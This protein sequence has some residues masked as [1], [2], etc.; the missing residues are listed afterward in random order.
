MIF[1]KSKI[2]NIIFFENA[3][4]AQSVEHSL[5]KAEV[6][7]SILLVGSNLYISKK[8]MNYKCKKKVREKLM[9]ICI[10]CGN[11]MENDVEVCEKCGTEIKVVKVEPKEEKSTEPKVKRVKTEKTAK[12]FTIITFLI[13][14]LQIAIV[15][16][17]FKVNMLFGI[18]LLFLTFAVSFVAT[19]ISLITSLCAESLMLIVVNFSFF[20]LE[21]IWGVLL[22]SHKI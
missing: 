16:P 1:T 21:M 9:K 4:I 22:I 2:M 20:A 10:N 17:L 11:Q 7:S 14:A 13:I 3:Y 6:G 12:V 19:T 5:G 18:L 8:Y 15:T